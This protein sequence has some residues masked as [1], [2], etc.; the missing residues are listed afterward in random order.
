MAATPQQLQTLI[1]G[2][3][4]DLAAAQ[5]Q[6]PAARSRLAQAQ[7]SGNQL[8]IQSEQS[9]L[10]SLELTIDSLEQQIQQ[11][12]T[13]LNQVEQPGLVPTPPRSAG[14]I[15]DDDSLATPVRPPPL[16]A[17]PETGRV[18]P[19]RESTLPTN[20][21][22]T[23]T[24]ATG[25]DDF[26]LDNVVRTL[27]VTQA[28]VTSVPRAFTQAV[29]D[30]KNGV[31]GQ[32]LPV[33]DT[34]RLAADGSVI[35][36]GAQ[37]AVVP[38]TPGVG[39]NDDNIPATLQSNEVALNNDYNRAAP[40]QPQPNLLDNFA[41]YTYGVS[42][43]LLT[44]DQYRT[45]VLSGQ[46]NV[47][48][49]NLLFQSGGDSSQRYEKRN[50]GTEFEFSEAV[51]GRSDFFDV[52]F[53]IDSVTIN[54]ALPGQQTQAAHMVTDIKFTVIEPNGITLL[55]RL[56]QAVQQ[57][58]PQSATGAI[59]YTAAQYL[60]V[61]RWYGYDYNGNLIRNV[62]AT[63]EGLSDPNA[64]IEK[65]IPFVIKNIKWTVSNRL[66]NYDFECAPVGQYTGTTTNKGTIFYD[67]ELSEGTVANLLAGAAV[68][69][70]AG[71]V[72]NQAATTANSATNKNP[73]V[74]QGL[75]SALNQFQQK[76]VD[77]GIYEKADIYEIEFANGAEAIRDAVLVKPDIDNRLG[78]GRTI[79]RTPV[80]PPPTVYPTG[81]DPSRLPVDA[82]IRNIGV[83]AGQQ[84]VQV[85]DLIIRN[86]SFLYSQSRITTTEDSDQYYDVN[87]SPAAI[88]EIFWYQLSV[89]A[90]PLEYD[91]KRNDFAYR[92][93]YTISPY[94]V[95]NFDSKYFPIPK[96]S[97]IH[98]KYNYWFTGENISVLE[99]EAKFDHLY[100]ILV[101]GGV[102]GDTAT[103]N[104]RRKFTSSMREIPKYVFGPG[105]SESR[106]GAAFLGN[107]VGANAADYLYN[108]S[109]LGSTRLR[110]VGDPAWIQQGSIS[111]G[112][113]GTAF[114]YN[115]FL[116]DGTI[117]FDV[118]QI[119]FEIAWQRPTDY[120]PNSGL[121]DPYATRNGQR[122]PQQ[123]YI[124]Q[125]FRVTSE[126]RQGR[127][128]QVIEG[129]L[130]IFPVPN[131][132]NT[133]YNK[134]TAVALDS[135]GNNPRDSAVAL[136]L[137][138]LGTNQGGQTAAPPPLDI[139]T[140][141]P[142]ATPAVAPSESAP[143]LAKNSSTTSNGVVVAVVDLSAPLKLGQNGEIQLQTGNTQTMAVAT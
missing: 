72:N 56:Y 132:R 48:G 15:V 143:G 67:L 34:P 124:Y 47:A 85:L 60:M 87:D 2:L 6:L 44:P 129:G 105:S 97:G 140:L 107:E 31:D 35:R 10:A 21:T 4:I 125:A 100:N 51:S 24:E 117:N 65:F 64:A 133:V 120:D 141:R 71:P 75:F 46:R 5:G 126:F 43:Y 13:A 86:S 3:L 17:D 41:S 69:N 127:F 58:K 109:T 19:I 104:L 135:A 40:I 81:L 108:P 94:R 101:S 26:G 89:K 1:R 61:L 11:A 131:P 70:N 50:A 73:L 68:V 36:P 84:I 57:A 16:E 99:Y 52:D 28:A 110:I 118:Q 12:E 77:D 93:R 82:T 139:V 78:T 62:S 102:K 7:R 90:T 63:P 92:V 27:A 8:A 142:D 39:Q 33:F 20:A 130:Y 112:V 113:S 88:K 38:R 49:Y 42:V 14:Q 96:F 121:A 136:T 79:T 106:T 83:S 119:M 30:I 54:N 59:N 80:A 116:A 134:T 137:A 53:Y 91:Y 18:F 37:A 29:G 74:K 128:E 98:K 9:R 22:V 115:G 122:E 25:D 23:P 76:L 111:A 103:E 66:V 138:Q 55:D 95:Q 123:S 32:L 45:Y 114:N